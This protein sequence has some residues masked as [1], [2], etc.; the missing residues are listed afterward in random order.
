MSHQHKPVQLKAMPLPHPI[1]LNAES[2]AVVAVIDLALEQ[3]RYARLNGHDLPRLSSVIATVVRYRK[4]GF[5]FTAGDGT[6]AEF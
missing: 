1:Y 5:S 2:H 3:S 6:R 4:H